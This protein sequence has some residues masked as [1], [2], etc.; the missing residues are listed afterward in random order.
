MLDVD[1]IEAAP[2]FSLLAPDVRRLALIYHG[3]IRRLAAEVKRLRDSIDLIS[4]STCL[5]ACQ[6]TAMV[7]IGEVGNG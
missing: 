4:S 1:A 3:D 6:G 5:C 2:E 7:T